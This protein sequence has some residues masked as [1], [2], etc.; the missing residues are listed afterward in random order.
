M[1]QN[2]EIKIF[3][4][5]FKGLTEDILISK[6]DEPSLNI[7]TPVNAELIVLAN[8]NK[9]FMRVL[10]ESICTFD[11]QIP[12]LIAKLRFRNKNFEKL[13]G[14]DV[15]YTICKY[16][17]VKNKK[18]FLLGGLKDSNLNSIRKLKRLHPKLKIDGFSPEYKPY[19][20]DIAHN[21]YILSKINKF[22]P[23]ILFVAFGP[24]KQEY[25]AHDNKKILK[26]IGVK[27]VICVGGTFEFISSKEK[28]APKFIQK[29]GLE[30]VWRLIQNPKRFKRFLS[31]FKIIK[32][33]KY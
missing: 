22:K 15:I 12:F 27:A 20:F 1:K 16:A 18:V 10:S 11:G 9:K 29:I 2:A 28:R 23:E 6:L 26:K 8:E 21:K 25:W 31:N 4:L 32:Y 5:T 13:S 33:L 7:I 17:E 24:P 3:N 19:P 30:S 14:S